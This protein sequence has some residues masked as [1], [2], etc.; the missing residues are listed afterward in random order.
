MVPVVDKLDNAV[1]LVPAVLS[2]APFIPLVYY[3]IL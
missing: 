1:H 2:Q 3:L